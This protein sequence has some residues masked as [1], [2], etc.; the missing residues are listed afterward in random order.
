MLTSPSKSPNN[1]LL[2][3]L[4][5]LPITSIGEPAFA[6]L[7]PQGS[8]GVVIA[9]FSRSCWLETTG[10]RLFAVA[11][12]RLGEG[13]LTVGV[14][15]P[16]GL[17]LAEL[18]VK[19]GTE[20]VADGTDFRLGSRLILRTAAMTLWRPAPLGP[21][22]S[23]DEMARRLRAL[24]DSVAADAPAEGLA[25]LINHLS[26]MAYGDVPVPADVGLVSRLAMPKVAPA[27]QGSRSG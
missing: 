10:G 3:D 5:D 1:D 27:R 25:P 4:F 19:Q 11:D 18:G 16:E 7:P 13:P 15:L 23:T 20:L 14:A 24:I 2:K 12:Q 6:L 21:R 26:Q 17:T 8:I 9:D 22:T